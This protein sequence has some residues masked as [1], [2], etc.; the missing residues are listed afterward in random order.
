MIATHPERVIEMAVRG[1]LPKNTLGRTLRKKLKV[2]AG[3]EHPHQGQRPAP[4]DGRTP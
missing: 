4:L 2:Y 3:G 1:M